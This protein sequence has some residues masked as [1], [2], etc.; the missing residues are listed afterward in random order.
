MTSMRIADSA[1]MAGPA[2]QLSISFDWIGSAFL[3]SAAASSSSAV[4][5]TVRGTLYKPQ[6]KIRDERRRG[7]VFLP[8]FMIYDKNIMVEP[9]YNKQV[10]VKEICFMKMNKVMF[11]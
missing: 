10:Y 2:G 7:T 6:Q 1:V 11:M 3:S 4:A 8:L 5:C 9:F